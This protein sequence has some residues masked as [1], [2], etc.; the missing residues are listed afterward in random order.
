MVSAS[1]LQRPTKH[2]KVRGTTLLEIVITMA[3]MTV[4]M[5]GFF[6]LHFRS[7]Q[8]SKAS[9]WMSQAVSIASALQDSL[10]ALPYSPKTANLGQW[11]PC[12]DMG[13]DA[14]SDYCHK[15]DAVDK[16]GRKTSEDDNFAL[17]P[18]YYVNKTIDSQLLIMVRVRYPSED[19]MAGWKAVNLTSMRSMTAY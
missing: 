10:Q 18:S 8:T 7:L 12:P 13:T 16:I 11:E 14:L 19:V 1:F 15:L 3:I 2:K 4:G 5:L 6:T 17:H 9:V